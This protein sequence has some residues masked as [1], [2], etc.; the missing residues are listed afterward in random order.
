[1]S[2]KKSSAQRYRTGT[3]QHLKF[4]KRS[5][6]TKTMNPA[7]N[8]ASPEKASSKTDERRNFMESVINRVSTVESLC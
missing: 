5:S 7:K 3:L 1:M 4:G 8:E 6:R 2:R